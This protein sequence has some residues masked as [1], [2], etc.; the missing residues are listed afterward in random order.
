MTKAQSPRLFPAA[1]A[2]TLLAAVV[3]AGFGGSARA[4]N[5]LGGPAAD[6]ARN[7][8]S[9]Q[10]LAG[11][12]FGRP[13]VGWAPYEAWIKSDIGTTCSAVTPAFARAL[14]RFRAAHGLGVG[15]V[16]DAPTFAAFRQIWALR[17]PFV[18]VSKRGCP[19][20]PAESTL[21]TALAAESFGGKV[22]QLRPGALTAYRR[23]AAAAR[24]A[25]VTRS[26]PR[27]LTIFSGYR[28][29]A[30]DAARCATE[31]NCQGVT[32][33]SCSAHLTGLAMDLDLG[34]TPGHMVDSS[35][36]VNRTVMT[37]TPAYRWLVLNAARYGFVNYVFEPW[38]WE[39]TGEPP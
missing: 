25:G 9:F 8:A 32:R 35:D 1:A 34:A 6:A 28:S 29:P 2:L 38:H 7:A 31:G 23:L 14:A 13:E 16:L 33:A 4:E 20:A 12:W 3:L 5:C 24:A 30:A 11:N 36:D 26:D 22:I 10:T 17:R 39:W 27:L 18:L 19:A 37:Y 15:G 21:A